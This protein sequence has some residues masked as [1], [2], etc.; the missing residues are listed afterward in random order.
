[1]QFILSFPFTITF[2]VNKLRHYDK[3][4][5]TA[6]ILPDFTFLRKFFI[7][8]NIIIDVSNISKFEKISVL[9][10]VSLKKSKW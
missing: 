9:F 3:E 1:M 2:N 10:L 6:S 5:V 8:T 4:V 7:T